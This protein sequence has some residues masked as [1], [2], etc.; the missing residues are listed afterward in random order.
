MLPWLHMTLLCGRDQNWDLFTVSL[1]QGVN[2]VYTFG[3]LLSFKYISFHSTMF[4]VNWI[5]IVCNCNLRYHN[6]TWWNIWL[7]TFI[8]C[9]SCLPSHWLIWN[10]MCLM[11]TFLFWILPG[12][13]KNCNLHYCILQYNHYIKNNAKVFKL[14]Y[15]I[16]RAPQQS[17]KDMDLPDII[18]YEK[19]AHLPRL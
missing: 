2:K 7:I 16:D 14:L 13:H 9:T 19:I 11:Q 1:F 6:F 8:F 18:F 3:N 17:K 4:Q 10:F 15:Q 12:K 5:S